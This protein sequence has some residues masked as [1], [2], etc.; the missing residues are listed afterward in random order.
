MFDNADEP[1]VHVVERFIPPGNRGNILITSRNRSMGRAISFKNVIEINEMEEADAITLLLKASYLDALPEHIEVAK[2]IV[3]ELGCMPLAVD[4]AGAYIEAGR[5][6]IYEYLQQFTLHR[7]TL[8]SDATFRGASKYD[9]TVYGTW[10]LSFTEIKKRAGESNTGDAQA[11]HAAILILQICAFYHYSNIS[12][13]IFRSAAEESREHV[14]NSEVE[15][16]IPLAMSSLD[17]TLLALDNNGCWDELIFGKGI[18]VLLSFSLV[19]RDQ[20]SEMLSI[21]PLV[22]CWSREQISKSEQQR[23]YDMGG[24][25]L[26][27]AISGRL[28]SYDFGL[29]R[30]IFSHIKANESYGSQM[31]L[32]K[33]YYDDKW[34]NFIFVMDEIGDWKHAEQLGV[35]M[36]DMR[37]KVLGEE[38]PRTLSSMAIL[39]RTYANMGNLNKAEQL[40]VQVLEKRKKVL[41]AEHPDTHTSMGN[42]AVTY[43]NMGNLNEAKQLGV[44]ALEMRKKVLGAEHPYTLLS[45]AN[46]A[47]T[48]AEMG[49]LNE[50]E[51]LEVQVL[52]MRKKVLGAEHP[53]TL[54]SMANVAK[55]YADMGNLNKAEQLGVQVLEMR[56]KVLGEEH[57][58]TL[59]SM[60]ILAGTYVDMGNLNV[61]A[62]LQAQLLKM[63]KKVLGADHPNTLLSM[64]NLAST[65]TDIGNLNEAEQLGVQLLEMR[66]KVLGAEHPQTLL[67]MAI[68]AKTYTDLR[69]LNEAEELEVQVMDIRKKVLG[70]E[71]PDTLTSMVNLAAT[72]AYM[73]NLNEAEQ[74][75]VQVLEMKKKVLG[76]D[77][78]DTLM[79]M[80]DLAEIYSSQG[81]WNG[82]MKMWKKFRWLKLIKLLFF[83]LMNW[84]IINL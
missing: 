22:H 67:S 76:E 72:Y 29:R 84:S 61:A 23:M 77:H 19:K 44:Q 75:L 57:P 24:I 55:T 54:S 12:K 78:P 4:Q 8:M 30:L 6:S 36:L 35:Q 15:E 37:K 26:C 62:E 38:H 81:K 79:S 32:I 11:A 70:A 39:A 74:L 33:K 2:D 20:S 59:L 71:H 56:K 83:C 41:G 7:Q 64:A 52:D 18:A 51:Q 16:K 31:G 43:A 45:M 48:Y 66:K 40:E 82:I 80:E 53:D 47:R 1:P 27:C 58:Q 14:V 5:C 13:D 60:A 65:Y 25:I 28:S 3:A 68:L 50:A 17:R 42:L 46:L 34:N 63:R 10:D 49:N 69:K 73:G 9:R 21:H